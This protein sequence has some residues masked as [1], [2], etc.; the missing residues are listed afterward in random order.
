MDSDLSARLKMAVAV[1]VAV[2]AVGAAVWYPKRA[3]IATPKRPTPTADRVA[4]TVTVVPPSGGRISAAPEAATDPGSPVAASPVPAAPEEAAPASL[5]DVISRA[6]PAVVR[7]ETPDGLGSAFFVKR[8]TMLTNVH[9]VAGHAVVTV[10]LPDGRAVQ[11]HVDA[12]APDY[13]LAVVK[14]ADADGSPAQLPLGSALRTRVGQEIVAVGS[15]L[16]LQNTVTRGI[17]SALRQVGSVMLV[18]TDAAIN[19]GNSGG[20]LVDRSGRVVAIATMR[21]K[22]GAGQGLSFGVAAEHAQALLDGRLP[23]AGADAPRAGIRDFVAP[24]AAAGAGESVRALGE[25]AFEQTVARVAQDADALDERWRGFVGTCY[26][27]PIGGGFDRPWFALFEARAMQGTVPAGCESA[28]G[29][30]KQAAD[31]IRDA[32]LAADEAARRADV[33]P[34]ARRD[35]LRRHGLDYAGWSQ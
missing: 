30:L 23:I 28:F 34:G 5:E 17:V 7:V 27:G 32:I 8:D 3:R 2:G 18:Q 35:A 16:G 6:M 11:G 13:D 25:R 22:P 26:R 9:V 33:Y 10:H 29:S 4:P 24:Q 1:L 20:P 14:V 31:R 19:P 21:V 12:T 15:P